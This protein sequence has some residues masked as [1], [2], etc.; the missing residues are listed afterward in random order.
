MMFTAAT[1]AIVKPLTA[2]S[3]IPIR[4]TKVGSEITIGPTPDPLNIASTLMYTR[5]RLATNA[6]LRRIIATPDFALEEPVIGG[7]E[8]ESS[9]KALG[10]IC[11]ILLLSIVAESKTPLCFLALTFCPL[12][13]K[14]L[15]NTKIKFF[16]P[17]D[18]FNVRSD[19]FLSSP[20]A[21]QI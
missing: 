3:N 17:V 18:A 4:Y 14:Y 16:Q 19:G 11:S 6:K 20:H 5:P 13:T 7:V 2:A 15:V 1:A 10:A 12:L 21:I 8:N 9:L